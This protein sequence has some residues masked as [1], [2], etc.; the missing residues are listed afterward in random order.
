M[1]KFYNTADS[2]C[3]VLNVTQYAIP[4]TDNATRKRQSKEK[5]NL[6]L[7]GISEI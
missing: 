7:D 6:L 1:F 2:Y 4:A 5:G 3:E